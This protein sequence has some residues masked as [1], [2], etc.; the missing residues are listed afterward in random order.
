MCRLP[1]Q[2]QLLAIIFSSE[3]H[4]DD[5]HRYAA[6]LQAVPVRLTPQLSHWHAVPLPIPATLLSPDHIMVSIDW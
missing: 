6:L 3:F 2:L 5:A 4:A 1:R